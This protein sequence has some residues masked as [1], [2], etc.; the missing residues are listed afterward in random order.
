MGKAAFRRGLGHGVPIA[1]GY[2]SVAFA[3]GIQAAGGGLTPLQ[4]VLISMTNL[5][6]AGQVAG[7]SLMVAG[8]PLYEMALTQL[9][10]NLRYAL[11]SLSLSQRLDA[12]MTTPWR[13]LLAFGNTDEIFAVASSQPG[14]IGRAYLTGLICLPYV[15]WAGGTLLGAAAGALLPALLT[16][17]LGI[18]IYGMF[19]AV[20]LPPARSRRSVR[21]VVVAAAVMS[22]ILRYAPAFSSISGGFSIILCAVSAAALG[23]WRF[24]VREAE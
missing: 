11:M 23:A 22:C 18:A 16:D 7:L 6:S 20:I 14:E 9:V 1:L 19:L 13:A 21:L 15:G 2:L 17:A 12:G 10:I 3:F 24:P 4:A 5:T 8:A